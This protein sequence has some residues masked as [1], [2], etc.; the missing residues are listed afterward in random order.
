MLAVRPCEKDHVNAIHWSNKDGRS[1]A[2]SAAA[3]SKILY[4]ILDWD[5]DYSYRIPAGVRSR[6]GE[7]VIFFDLDNYIGRAVQKKVK[8]EEETEEM[9]EQKKSN[10]IEGI[11]YG[12]DDD[13]EPQPVEDLEALEEKLR[14][15]AEVEKLTFGT[16]LFEHNGEI[17]LPEIDSG[18]VWNVMAEAKILD[19]EHSVDRSV[20]EALQEELLEK[21]IQ[22][23]EGENQ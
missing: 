20:V 9:P 12:A 23:D 22:N 5:K 16:P 17:R 13:E 7:T 1:I 2:V 19:D 18:E 10:S 4:E 14:K 21:A 11:F 8:P 15:I 3:F 6:N